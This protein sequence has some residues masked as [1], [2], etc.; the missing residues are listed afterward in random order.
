MVNY[1]N[2]IHNLDREAK[3]WGILLGSW[4]ERFTEIFFNRYLNLISLVKKYKIDK[5]IINEDYNHSLKFNFTSEIQY[6]CSDMNWNLNFYSKMIKNLDLPIKN[7]EIIYIESQPVNFIDEKKG[8]LFKNLRDLVLSNMNFSGNPDFMIA[9]TGLKLFDEIK[10]NYLLNKKFNYFYLE[11][12]EKH[13]KIKP[14]NKNLRYSQFSKFEIKDKIDKCFFELL[15]ECIPNIYLE[16]YKDNIDKVKSSSLPRKVK[17]IFTLYGYDVFDFFKLWT[18]EQTVNGAKYLVGQHGTFFSRDFKN[19]LIYKS[20]D[21]FFI[22]ENKKNNKN[23]EFF[24]PK[25][26]YRDKIN[27]NKNGGILIVSRARRHEC[28]FYNTGQDYDLL[29]YSYVNLIKKISKNVTTD[30]TFRFRNFKS[31]YFEEEKKILEKNFPFIKFDYG[32]KKIEKIL[33]NYRLCLFNYNSTGFLENLSYGFPSISYWSNF[34]VHVSP[35]YKEVI[36]D[37]VKSGLIFKDQDSLVS[38]LKKFWSKVDVWW[39]FEERKKAI[40]NIV[41]T[42]S[43]LPS[44][45]QAINELKNILLQC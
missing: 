2:I 41:R 8:G 10:L 15:I 11:K 29:I 44:K 34:Y 26:I 14:Y 7:L 27:L 30:I 17:K 24:N 3:Y 4:F 1:L 42:Y 12:Y 16:S 6:F 18:A 25:L 21:N 38:E 22:W 9:K 36:D 45:K 37:M 33:K 39:N 20:F 28:E 35:A 32:D 23:I 31:H 40:E 13:L 5:V 19:S 43:K